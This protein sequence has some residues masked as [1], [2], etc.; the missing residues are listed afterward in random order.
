[1][2]GAAET[3]DKALEQIGLE[4]IQANATPTRDAAMVRHGRA[5]DEAHR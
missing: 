4:Y 1:M 5:V 3:D 2:L